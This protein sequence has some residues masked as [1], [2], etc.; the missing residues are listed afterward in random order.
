MVEG[1]DELMKD[2][3][4]F[5]CKNMK[6]LSLFFM[7][8]FMTLMASAQGKPAVEHYQI[9]GMQLEGM[10]GKLAL[11]KESLPKLMQGVVCYPYLDRGEVS[12]EAIVWED[13]P[14]YVLVLLKVE[15]PNTKR[16]REQYVATY[17]HKS[18]VIDAVL[19]LVSGDVTCLAAPFKFKDCGYKISENYSKVERTDTGFVVKRKFYGEITYP[20]SYKMKETGI[21]TLPYK[22]DDNGKM[23]M[24]KSDWL[25]EKITEPILDGPDMK[26]RVTRL[27]DDKCETIL[28]DFAVFVKLYCTPLSVNNTPQAVDNAY[29]VVNAML[30]GQADD[31]KKETFENLKDFTTLWQERLMYR[32]PQQ[33]AEWLYENRKVTYC[34]TGLSNIMVQD[35]DFHSWLKTQ[36][37][38]VKDKKV[39]KWWD[40]YLKSFFFIS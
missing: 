24:M 15:Y 7:A 19:A 37:S 5:N 22:V 40:N 27:V 39:R 35:P 3:K 23:T 28:T 18:G 12:L 30:V 4:L 32:K 25:S 14:N 1:L 29:G 8:A 13:N 6:K 11:T 34:L 17:G 21:W 26:A 9:N 10:N 33:W 38:S 31:S 20:H 36:V 2:L 16:A